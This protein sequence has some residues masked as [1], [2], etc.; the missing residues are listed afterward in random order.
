MPPCVHSCFIGIEPDA[1]RAALLS[2]WLFLFIPWLLVAKHQPGQR[3]KSLDYQSLV[4]RLTPSIAASSVDSKWSPTAARWI[5][6]IK[7]D[8]IK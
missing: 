4:V 1:N 6:R 3:I 5:V 2:C 7:H 8:L